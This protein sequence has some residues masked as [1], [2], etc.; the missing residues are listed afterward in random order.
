MIDPYHSGHWR[1]RTLDLGL[2]KEGDPVTR[3]P[4]QRVAPDRRR[5]HVRLQLTST[6]K[7]TLPP[8]P[9]ELPGSQG[10]SV[11]SGPHLPF[12]QRLPEQPNMLFQRV[13]DSSENA[14]QA[15]LGH[16]RFISPRSRPI[17][18]VN[19]SHS[20]SA[21]SARARSRCN[22]PI[23]RYSCLLGCFRLPSQQFH[24]TVALSDSLFVPRHWGVGFTV[25]E[26]AL[27][28]SPPSWSLTR[29]NAAQ[30]AEL[31]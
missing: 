18:A 28:R 21:A 7:S 31:C 2:S 15:W 1:W 19:S 11:A 29:G 6:S 24:V 22:L 30:V 27:V 9:G 12:D 23:A 4:P 26:E 5:G 8:P 10:H 14:G 16:Q 13:G 25:V 3:L 17:S 20:H